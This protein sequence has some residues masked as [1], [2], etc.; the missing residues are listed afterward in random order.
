[1]PPSRSWSTH[2]HD[3]RVPTGMRER[4]D[5]IV[6]LTDAFAT[7]HLDDEYAA[8][9][10]RMAM[11]LATLRPPP[12]A[13]GEP[14]TWAAAIV[15]AVGW[16]NLLT[17]PA[18]R[19]HLT[20]EELAALLRVSKGSMT[21]RGREVRDALDLVPMDPAWWRPSR[22]LD[23]PL[24][25]LIEVNGLVLDARLLPRAVQEE[26]F[27]AGVIPFVPANATPPRVG[28]TAPADPDGMASD[29]ADEEEWL[30]DGGLLDAWELSS[31]IRP[32]GFVAESLRETMEEA[33]AL[34]ARLRE[35]NP[36]VTDDELND[37]LT[38]L[39]DRRNA[40]PLAAFGGL[41]PNEVRRLVDADWS[42]PG[43]A[44]RVVDTLSLD[45]LASSDVLA[46]ARTVLALLAE[47]GAVKATP[48]GNLPRA[49]VAAFRERMRPVET[50]DA[51]WQATHPPRNE[52]DL[53]ALHLARNLLELAGL[54]KRRR[55]AF[56]RT[57]R[58]ERLTAPERAGELF[59]RLFVTM[60]R[61]MNLAWLDGLPEVPEFQETLGFTLHR[62]SHTGEAWRKADEAVDA[63]LLPAVRDALPPRP[64]VDDAALMLET[65]LLRPL[66]RFGL[67]ES[68]Q[69]ER[70]PDELLAR[71][72]YRRTPLLARAVVFDLGVNDG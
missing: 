72:S 41:S 68:R 22:I 1:M 39:V 59:A 19:P 14:R 34:V 47:Q 65:R 15:H 31:E 10:R 26:A 12:I 16:V 6:A 48:K 62:F 4:V 50:L 35:R 37:A 11:E 52:E 44:I 30:D 9:C 2:D 58:G 21:Q 8:L 28:W 60:F 70:E 61:Q 56:S 38:A 45:E 57:R 71:P 33:E 5:E 64:Y 25:W 17:D 20:T 67:A 32:G 69:N 66:V 53:G 54:V 40:Q 63:L 55:G 49:F 27:R 13:R 51:E 23:N 42:S 3:S 36:D 24:A 7:A 46:D 29:D 43:S 18:Q